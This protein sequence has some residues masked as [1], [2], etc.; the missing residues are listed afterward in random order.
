MIRK[1]QKQDIKLH[2]KENGTVHKQ[3]DKKVKGNNSETRR[4]GKLLNT[5]QGIATIGEGAI[6]NHVEGGEDIDK[7]VY[8]TQVSS[9]AVKKMGANTTS[10]IRKQKPTRNKSKKIVKRKAIITSKNIGKKVSKKIAKDSSKEVTKSTAKTVAKVGATTAG[11]TAGPYGTVIGYAVGEGVGSTIDK[12]DYKYTQRVRKIKFLFDKL[13]APD[14]QKDSIVKLVKDSVTNFVI[15]GAKRLVKYLLPVVLALSVVVISVGV[16][17]LGIITILYN[18]PLALFLPPLSEGETIH[19]VTSQYVSEFNQEVQGLVDEHKDADKGR[20]VYV[21]YEGMSITPSNYYDI[22]CVYMVKYGYESTAIEMSETN[23]ENLLAVV[24]DMC[25]YTTK[26]TV[27]KEGDEKNKKD[28]KYLDVD[29]DL[30]TYSEMTS[31]YSFNEEQIKMLSYLMDTYA[32]SN[33]NDVGIANLKNKLTPEELGA[34]T[35]KITDETQKT[36]V[37]FALSKVGYP[38]SQEKRDSGQAYDCSSLAYYAWKSA[39]VDISNEDST[40]AAA[41]AK[42]LEDNVIEEKDLQPGDLIFY[43][44]TINGRYKN[45]SHVGIYVGDGK[46]VEAVDPAHGV[47]LGDYHGEGVVMIGRPSY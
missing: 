44:Y 47:C 34:L 16:I 13:Q 29:V 26:I 42:G 41:E 31:T 25:S 9:R 23:K 2:K 38:Y 36:V 27:E 17:V 43:S 18:S 4:K 20:V 33:S 8:I 45:I 12:I 39:G 15:F 32:S 22:M 6:T 7:A 5:M 37:S 30:K 3:K 40:S 19:S 11:S 10:V 1:E 14:K 24:N 21:D 46:M 35:D 28:V